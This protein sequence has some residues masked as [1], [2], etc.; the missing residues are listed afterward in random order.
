MKGFDRFIW[1]LFCVY[2]F[3]LPFENISKVIWQI[4]S[5]YRPYRVLALL[6]GV[7]IIISRKPNNLKFYNND[8]KLAWVYL[9]GLIPSAIAW[10]KGML[11]AESF[12]LTSLQYF[13]VLWIFLLIK[14]LPVQLKEIYTCLNVF[15]FGVVINSLYMI[16]LFGF[17][18]LGR[19]SGFMDN[20]NFAAF[21]C[22]VAFTFFLYQF[23]HEPATRFQTTGWLIAVVILLLGLLVTGSRSALI[24][25]AAS[26]VLVVF[27]RF[28]FKN[29]LSKLTLLLLPLGCLTLFIDFNSLV[30]A[31]PAWNRLV[32]LAGKEEARSTLWLQGLESFKDS[33][34]IGLGIEQFKNP[35]NYSRYVGATENVSVANQAGL[36]LHNDYLT[37]LVEYGILAFIC[38]VGFY[39]TLFNQ[40]YKNS[41]QH[42]NQFLF[43][44]VFINIALFSFFNS[45][46]QSHSMWFIYIVLG[47]I[48]TAKDKI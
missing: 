3:M 7:L 18:D 36:V 2:V 24:S 35:Q 4:E 8:L 30:D 46:F 27:Y 37:V 17:N 40:L 39:K 11:L 1:I 26:I 22:N 23:F 12:W 5:P 15:C 34:F 32:T 9:F 43:L 14:S 42:S 21:A 48:T 29:T 44:I 38:F 13:I 45:S 10:S 16:Y 25:F 41:I 19:Q 33:N 31:I 6:I 28:N 47:F 20:P